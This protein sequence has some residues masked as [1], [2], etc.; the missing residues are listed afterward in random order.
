M[1]AD[2]DFVDWVPTT[3]ASTPP[4]RQTLHWVEQQLRTEVIDVEEL[5]GGLSSAVHRLRLADAP[6]VVLRRFTLADWM[7]R[8]PHIPHD[9][10]RNLAML[11]EREL[12]VATP[13]LIAADPSGEACD[14]PAIIMTE[15]AGRPVIEPT[16]P[17]R[18]AESIARCL[19][20]I[21]EQQ[22]GDD[23]PRYRRW[24]D[25]KRPVP[26]W[27]TDEQMWLEA[28]SAADVELPA[29]PDGFLHRDY[30]P[31]NIHWEA[32]EICAVVDWLS[33]C[34]GPLAGDLAHCRWNL[35][36]LCDPEL[37]DHFLAHYRMLTGYSED[38]KLFDLCTV[39]E[40]PV[41]P[42]PTHAWNA[43]GRIDLTSEVAARRIDRWLRHLLAGD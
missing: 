30:H 7:A 34:T 8:E 11:G 25:A 35:A 21:H 39:L 12:G 20:S 38:V 27:T 33:I 31:N 29:H 4:P 17:T 13:V 10:A 9:E 32:G 26:T 41:G 18:W 2:D 23:V 28:I 16:N 15:V 6:N 14:V 3:S 1:T 24:N 40:A 37:A 22:P 43:L 19:A 36:V 42:F 5:V